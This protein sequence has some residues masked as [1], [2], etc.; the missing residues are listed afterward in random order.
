M[1]TSKKYR[2][3][4][5]HGV[6]HLGRYLLE[7]RDKEIVLSPTPQMSLT[8]YVDSDF[9][10]NWDAKEAPDNLDTA[11]SRSGYI[12]LFAGAPLHWRSKLQTIISLSTAKSELVALS[13]ATRFVKSMMHLLE[14]LNERGI[15]VIGSAVQWILL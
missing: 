14:E 10:G 7:T 11:R 3:K 4:N 6:K 12:V 2:R 13:V 15:K 9:A 8:C 5:E 1:P